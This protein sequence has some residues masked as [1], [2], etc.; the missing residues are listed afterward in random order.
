M[1]YAGGGAEG[2]Q[3]DQVPTVQWGRQWSADN[4]ACI[5]PEPSRITHDIHHEQACHLTQASS[6]SGPTGSCGPWLANAL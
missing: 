1:A 4:N 2:G 3:A 5:T 6:P